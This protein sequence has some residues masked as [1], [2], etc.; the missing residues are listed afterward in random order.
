M[1]GR[2]LGSLLMHAFTPITHT[3]FHYSF[4]SI[5]LSFFILL[6][7]LLL[8]YARLW[9]FYT[10]C[11]DKI[12]HFYPFNHFLLVVGVLPGLPTSLPVAQPPPL[13]CVGYATPH[14]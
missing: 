12:Y 3:F 11:R 8:Y 13:Y 4:F 6:L 2:K 14:S 1:R 7:L 9:P 5:F 10:A